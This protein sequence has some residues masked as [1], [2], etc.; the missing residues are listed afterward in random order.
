MGKHSSVHLRKSKASG[1]KLANYGTT[2]A[3]LLQLG[4][5]SSMK[6]KAATLILGLALM[7][8]PLAL[9]GQTKPQTKLPK[10]VV[11]RTWKVTGKFV[12]F[13]AGD[14]VHALIKPKKGEENSTFI[15]GYGLDYFLAVNANKTGEF[16]VQTVKTYVQEEG[17][18][19]RDRSG[20]LGKVWKN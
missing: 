12:G 8:Q 15:N 18:S 3:S 6:P 17:G 5:K 19:D 20:H 9:S 13:E 14:Y 4:R 7:S 10:D 11:L 16:T 2:G 1:Q